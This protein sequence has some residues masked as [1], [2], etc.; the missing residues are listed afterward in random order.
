MIKKKRT[1]KKD[2]KATAQPPE[3]KLQEVNEALEEARKVPYCQRTA[4]QHRSISSLK[5][6][7]VRLR[8]RIE[9]GEW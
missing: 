1:I 9:T 8:N 3:D 5:A 7:Q 2:A 4:A 6:Y